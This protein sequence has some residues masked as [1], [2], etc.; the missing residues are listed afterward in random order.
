[1]CAGLHFVDMKL[2]Y[3]LTN[4]IRWPYSHYLTFSVAGAGLELFMNFFHVGEA[5]IYRSIK[6]NLSTERAE[7]TFEAEK[8]VFERVE[9]DD[10]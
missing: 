1:M 3:L 4:Y 10:E 9:A 6:K 2:P 5:S 7:S 8:S